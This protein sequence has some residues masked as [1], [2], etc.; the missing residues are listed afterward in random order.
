MGRSEVSTGLVKCNEVQRSVV[1][2]SEGLSNRVS[3]F[4]R[5]YTDH[6]KFV[7]SFIIFWFQFLS[8]YIWL[9]VLCASV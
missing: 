5:R 9:Y 3:V 2:R 7:V 1:T 8:S 4:I 6:R